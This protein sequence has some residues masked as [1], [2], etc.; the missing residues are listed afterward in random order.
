MGLLSSILGIIG[1]GVAKGVS[2]VV[3][4]AVSEAVKP[5]AAKLAKK[6]ADMIE[7]VANDLESANKSL[8]EASAAADKA[9][10]ENPEDLKRAV[11][12]L[13]R[14]AE[15][16]SAEMQQELEEKQLTDE[17]VMAQWETLLPD[18]PKWECGGNHF[19]LK[20]ETYDD[21]EYINFQ[22]NAADASWL[23]YRAVL[24]ANGF[25][26]KYRHDTAFWYKEMEGRYPAVHLFDID[27]ESGDLWLKYYYETK[28]EIEE[29]KKL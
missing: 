16:A 1:R 15:K 14:S 17:E 22:L 10:T 7:S 8:N 5:A 11:E 23:A 24:V 26:M 13:R 12:M 6:Q 2:N 9:A 21:G 19:S 27:Y 4:N 25:K 20:K 29:A 18:F 28:E 3:E